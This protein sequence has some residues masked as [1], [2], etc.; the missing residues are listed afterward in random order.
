[1]NSGIRT[2]VWVPLMVASAPLVLLIV[3]VIMAGR[4][5]REQSAKLQGGA[6]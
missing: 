4:W 1:M 5:V 2:A 6:R 3:G